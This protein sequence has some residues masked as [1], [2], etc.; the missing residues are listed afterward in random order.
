[1]P[2]ALPSR[3]L[4]QVVE[5]TAEFWQ[6]YRGARMLLTGAT[7]FISTWL[8][9][10]ARHANAM[11]GND[12]QVVAPSRDPDAACARAIQVFGASHVRFV[13]GGAVSFMENANTWHYSRL[14]SGTHRNA[15][16]ELGSAK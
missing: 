12:I 1:M 16:N 13:R 15:M 3:D 11:L 7:G 9:E 8:V 14:I 6:R 5:R 10:I 4:E 2:F